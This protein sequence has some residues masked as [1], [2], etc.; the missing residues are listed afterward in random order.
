LVEAHRVGS[1]AEHQEGAF[2]VFLVPT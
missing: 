2:I 1:C